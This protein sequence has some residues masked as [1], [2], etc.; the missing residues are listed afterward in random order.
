M[1]LKMYLVERSP[2]WRL[3]LKCLQSKPN[4]IADFLVIWL[5]AIAKDFDKEFKFRIVQ[6]ACHEIDGSHVPTSTGAIRVTSNNHWALSIL[7]SVAKTLMLQ[8]GVRTGTKR[9]TLNSYYFLS[10][11][12]DPLPPLLRYPPISS[13]LWYETR[14]HVS[15]LSRNVPSSSSMD[16]PWSQINLFFGWADV[17]HSLW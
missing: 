3:L 11:W 6:V 8:A 15:T 16:H 2:R 10:L 5:F 4:V 13:V 12:L 9:Y 17:G 14:F 1:P 7:L